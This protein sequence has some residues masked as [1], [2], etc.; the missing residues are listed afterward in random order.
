MA[1]AMKGDIVTI[2]AETAKKAAECAI[3]A[4]TLSKLALQSEAK[5]PKKKPI[6]FDM[7]H[8]NNA[9]RIRLW[10]AEKGA[11]EWIETKMITY[12]DLQTEEFKAVNPLRKVPAFIEEDGCNLFESFVILEYLEDKYSMSGKLF[13][14]NTP[15]GR[16]K[17]GLLVRIH[18]IYI[19]SPNCTQPGFAHTQGC[20]Y[21]GPKES[22]YC[23]PWRVMKRDRRAKKLAEMFQQLTWLEANIDDNG[24]YMMGEQLTLADM[25]THSG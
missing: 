17:M 7:V 2:A 1:E 8:S 9:A 3:L 6:F 20:M 15:E 13:K 10:I 16:A 18:D 5:E 11:A 14:P 12:P 24:P 21:L 4:A 23:P 22:P 25:T 19:A